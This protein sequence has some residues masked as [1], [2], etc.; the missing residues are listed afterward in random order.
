VNDFFFGNAGGEIGQA[1]EAGYFEREGA[2]AWMTSGTVDMPTASAPSF[3]SIQT[4]AS[5]SHYGPI[6]PA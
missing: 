2:R 5:V 6:E 4:S 3:W 1:G